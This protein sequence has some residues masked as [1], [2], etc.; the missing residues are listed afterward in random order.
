MPE[1]TKPAVAWI[2]L[3]DQ[4]LPMAVA[5]AE[6]GYPLHVWARRPA[7]LQ[8]LGDVPYVRHHTTHDLGAACDTVGL[9]VGTD[10]DVMEIVSG[11]LLDG[12]RPGSVVVNH[13]T[14]IP[15]NAVRLTEIC[16]AA[17]VDV[18]DAPVSGGRPAAEA[19]TLTTL[20]GGP[21]SIAQRCEPLFR[22]FSRSV[23]YLGRS[24]SGQTAKLFNNALLMMNQASIA[25]IV[26]LAGNAGADPVR[27]VE[28]LKLGSA[29]SSALTLLNTM[30]TPATVEH[31]SKVE[32]EDMEIFAAAM[33]DSGVNAGPV[34]ARGLEG[35]NRLTELIRRLNP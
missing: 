11:G 30:V 1:N 5:I 7:S 35:A 31:L 3:G 8:A 20:V 21:E 32:A 9:C 29:S 23:V 18:L 26:E 13:G 15:G 25:E 6:S 33:A 28:A 12:L 2:G 22:S 14:G 16:A 10:D 19:R 17:G 24:G 4:G 34:T 27:L